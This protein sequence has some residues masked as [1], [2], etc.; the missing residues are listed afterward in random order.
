M[1]FKPGKSGNPQGRPRRT[2]TDEAQRKAIRDAVPGIVSALIQSASDGDTQAAKLLLDRVMPALRPVDRTV[3]LPL[4]DDIETA[5]RAILAALAGGKLTPDQATSIA[6]TVATLARV[7]EL[8][9]LETRFAELEALLK[10]QKQPIPLNE[11]VPSKGEPS[12]A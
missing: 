4:G 10:W 5:G 7:R 12:A 2:L 1:A 6:A 3:T 8:A 11:S 9:E